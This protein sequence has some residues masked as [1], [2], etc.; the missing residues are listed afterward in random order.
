M[1]ETLEQRAENFLKRYFGIYDNEFE[2][3][4]ENDEVVV[5]T[6]KMLVEFATENCIQ[7][8]KVA[9]KDLPEVNK[10]V[11]C[12]CHDGCK[13]VYKLLTRNEFK[14]FMPVYAWLEFPQFNSEEK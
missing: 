7:W 13:H 3:A 6:I 4:K 10:L 12:Y 2:K 5:N 9:D 1:A 8:H 11:L 14:L